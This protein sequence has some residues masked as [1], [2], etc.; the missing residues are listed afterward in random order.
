[1]EVAL[2]SSL[3]RTILGTNVV[4]IGRARDNGLVV[5]DPT[6]S[7]HHA[8]IRPDGQGYI[9]VDLGSTN[10]TFING[11]RLAINT[12]RRLHA[13]DTIR[14]GDFIITYEEEYLTAGMDSTN[15]APAIDE[16]IG[17]QP[18]SHPG[19]NQVAGS[20][21]HVWDIDEEEEVWRSMPLAPLAPSRLTG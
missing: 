12:P 11:Q 5:N 17:K 21:P 16:K 8:E 9:I 14:M 1:M 13:G 15:V 6:T 4:T 19:S 20:I 3:G 18:S 10:G 7:S 2:S